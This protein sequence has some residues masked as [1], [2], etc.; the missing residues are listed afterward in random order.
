LKSRKRISDCKI[1]ELVRLY[2]SGFNYKELE[3]KFDYSY[4]KIRK[5]V[6]RYNCQ[7]DVI[8]ASLSNG[9]V[10]KICCKYINTKVTSSDLAREF[11]ITQKRVLDIL[12]QEGVFD[13]KNYKGKVCNFSE[14]QVER[15]IELYKKDNVS[16]N[17][18][19]EKYGVGQGIITNLLKNNGINV[20][21]RGKV[22]DKAFSGELDEHKAYFIGFLMADGCV[23]KRGDSYSINLQVSERDEDIIFKFKD[24]LGAGNKIQ[25]IDTKLKNADRMVGISVSSH[26]IAEDLEAFNVSTNKTGDCFAT[27]CLKFNK[28]FW[29]GMVDGDGSLCVSDVNVILSLCNSSEKLLKQ[30]KSFCLRYC[31]F[32]RQVTRSFSLSGKCAEKMAEVLYKDS[33][34]YLERKYKIAKDWFG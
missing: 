5:W 28:N 6:R 25:Y 13:R 18:I 29:R 12:Y 26:D 24:F 27:E 14:S 33:N 2:N 11:D 16:S 20:R 4:S 10:E 15:I 23:Y 22:N 1:E 32:D 3:Q 7:I 21:R 9:D 8:P 19:G 34:I 31:N 17:K 30:F